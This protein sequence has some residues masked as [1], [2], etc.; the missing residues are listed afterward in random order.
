MYTRHL[1]SDPHA[2]KRYKL[3]KAGL[4]VYPTLLWLVEMQ[5]GWVGLIW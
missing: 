4:A 5:A 2:V 1:G 3:G